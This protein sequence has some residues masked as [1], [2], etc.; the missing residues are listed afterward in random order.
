MQ[1]EYRFA[2]RGGGVAWVTMEGEGKHRVFH[3][4]HPGPAYEDVGNVALTPDGRHVAYAGRA[5]GIWHLVVDG[6]QGASYDAPGNV[7]YSPDGNHLLFD[8]T[9][10]NVFKLL[11]DEQP[12]RES[13]KGFVSKDF[14]ADSS[15][16]VFMEA[17]DDENGRIAVADLEFKQV[18]VV[19]EHA[20]DFVLSEDKSRVTAPVRAEGGYRVLTF[21][22]DRPD[23]VRRGKVYERFAGLEF[24]GP[25]GW[26]VA[27]YALRS[28]QTY[29]VVEEEEIPLE[30]GEQVVG[31]AAPGPGLRGI[32][33]LVKAG[34]KVTYRQELMDRAPQEPAY[35]DALGVAFGGG[36]KLHAYA[37]RRGTS[38]FVVAN[39]TEGP[40]FDAVVTPQFS[41]DGSVLVYRARKEGTRFVVVADPHGKTIRELPRYE[42]VFDVR[43]TAD[44]RSIA[45]GVKDGR[46]LAW[47]VEPL[48]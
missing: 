23:R 34:G 27:Y 32:G 15:R 31:G 21:D 14:N 33:L 30:K 6:K 28:G 20:L 41:P 25:D 2:D 7:R 16:I 46:E 24:G 43:F 42:Q 13:A 39:G 36:G 18:T 9:Y 45:Y 12:R 11:V 35:D 10:G 38:W 37:A 17:V 26:P 29:F 19:D 22:A 5:G 44:G 3:D 48:R 8:A 40:P 1:V 4:G 47:K